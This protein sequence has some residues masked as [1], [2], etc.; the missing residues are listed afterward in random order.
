MYK[1]IS[2]KLVING[3]LSQSITVSRSVRQGCPLSPLLFNIYLEPLCRDIINDQKVQGFRLHAC[4]VK[5]LAYADDLVLICSDKPSIVN[6]MSLV[7]DYCAVSGA[8]VN[9]DKCS[10]SWCG[11]WGTTPPKYVDIQ[12]STN[13]PQLLGVPLSAMD[14]PKSMWDSIETKVK[15]AARMWSLRYLS[16]FG[17]VAVCNIFLLSKLTYLL[18]VM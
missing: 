4:E 5:L 1:E 10:G 11:V 16:T 8:S 6:A 12:W 9:R 15:S 17:K 18:Q 2:T 3:S 7:T 13:K 14:N